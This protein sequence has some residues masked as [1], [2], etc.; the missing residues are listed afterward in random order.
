MPDD[1]NPFEPWRPRRDPDPT[2][3]DEML[4][5]WRP[6]SNRP[7]EPDPNAGPEPEWYRRPRAPEPARAPRR[8]RSG[9]SWFVWVTIALIIAAMITWANNGGEHVTRVAAAGGCLWLALLLAWPLGKRRRWYTRLGIIVAGAAGTVAAWLFVPTTGGV[10]LWHAESVLASIRALPAGDVAG[11][12]AGLAERNRVAQEFPRFFKPIHDAEISWLELTVSQAVQQ[13]DQE[14]A[15]DPVAALGRLRKVYVTLFSSEDFN[16]ATNELHRGRRRAMASC[17]RWVEEEVGSLTRQGRFRAA[18]ERARRLQGELRDESRDLRMENV[19]Q[20]AVMAARD[21]NL[22]AHSAAAAWQLARLLQEKQFQAVAREGK[23][24]SADLLVEARALGRE[25]EALAAVRA[26]RGKALQ[27]RIAQAEG[28]LAA[29][30]AKAEYQAVPRKAK[31]AH[32]ELIDEAHDA[33]ATDLLAGA[34][35]DARRKAL[36]GRVALARKSLE[37]L[38]EKKDLAG[39]AS[40]GQRLARELAP[41]AQAL[42]VTAWRGELLALRKKALA[43]RL[44]AAR[45]ETLAELKKDRYQALGE[46]GE[47]AMT[48]LGA[49]AEAVGLLKELEK[50]RDLCRFYAKLAKE[51]KAPTRP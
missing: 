2:P 23:L 39:V 18:A 12:Q 25:Q 37:G 19:L 14:R 17:I 11:Y 10:N 22:Q 50:F 45:A 24:L 49:E 43:G 15:H 40:A 41:E 31:Q 16:D 21:D 1:I 35:R 34:F 33:R 42:N 38:L 20:G 51:A 13:A 44:D 48:D 30:V 3:D 47:R 36:D 32:D 9:A 8:D 5:H 28:E 6:P 27:A 26:L 29:L 7:S 4:R 46:A